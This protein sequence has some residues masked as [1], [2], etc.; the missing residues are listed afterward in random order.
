MYNFMN[1]S[2]HVFVTVTADFVWYMKLYTEIF[3]GCKKDN[4][5]M[6][7]CDNFLIFAQNIDNLCLRAK[8]RK[9]CLPL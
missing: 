7:N 9:I 1:K 3:N 8:I 2:V 5:Q 6:K 4:F